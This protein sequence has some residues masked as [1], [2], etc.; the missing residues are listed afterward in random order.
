MIKLKDLLFEVKFTKNNAELFKK[1]YSKDATPE[2][3]D[4]FNK[5]LPSLDNKDIFDYPS[6]EDLLIVINQDTKN[7]KKIKDKTEGYEK[8]F[9]NNKH[10]VYRLKTWE[11]AKFLGKGTKWC[12][13]AEDTD[14]HWKEYIRYSS[15]YV[16]LPDKLCV[17]VTDYNT[18]VW[19]ELDKKRPIKIIPDDIPENIF[20]YIHLISKL[21]VC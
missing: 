21:C 20:K 10:Q 2:L 13:S 17:Q 3:F 15:L 8:V 14:E 1:M 12:I 7:E 9:D 6:Y 19:N 18:V 5:V 16:I 4:R 11:G